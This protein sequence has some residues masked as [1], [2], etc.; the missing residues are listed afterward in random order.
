[1]RKW[2]A[3]V[4]AALQIGFAFFLIANGG[5]EDRARE[6]RIDEIVANGTEFL[7]ELNNFQYTV[8]PYAYEPIY[9]SLY[10][11]RWDYNYGYYPLTATDAGVAAFGKSVETPP[12]EPYYAPDGH[13]YCRIDKKIL[14]NLFAADLGD[15]DS[16][17]YSRS[18]FTPEKNRF[19]VNDRW[20][21]VYAIGYV[22]QGDIA[23]VGISVD[24]ARYG[25]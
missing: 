4:L 24:G 16:H 13:T 17:Y 11:A 23:F 18:W 2:I 6:A 1:M 19:L 5:R 14:H 7:F 8:E 25:A 12:P 9:F 21:S 20:V 15:S 3:L 10:D 22:Y